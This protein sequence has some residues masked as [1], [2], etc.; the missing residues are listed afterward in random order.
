MGPCRDLL[1]DALGDGDHDQDTFD[2][3]WMRLLVDNGLNDTEEIEPTWG[4]SRPGKAPNKNRDFKGIV[5]EE[6][7]EDR[8]LSKVRC[9]CRQVVEKVSCIGTLFP[10]LW[11]ET[12]PSLTELAAVP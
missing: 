3:W 9:V 5:I 2:V 6:R 12:C 4:G 11:S 10:S 8:I 1:I 7:S